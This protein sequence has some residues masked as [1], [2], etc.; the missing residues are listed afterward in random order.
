MN[1]R[2]DTHGLFIC[3]WRIGVFVDSPLVALV[4]YTLCFH[5]VMLKTHFLDDEMPQVGRFFLFC[6]GF[7]LAC[8]DLV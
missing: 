5:Q 2:A 3:L 1:C 6:L 4:L 7:Y 8:I